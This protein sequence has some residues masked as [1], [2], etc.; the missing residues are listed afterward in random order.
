MSDVRITYNPGYLQELMREPGVQQLVTTAALDVKRGIAS[1]LPGGNRARPFASKAYA[2]AATIV[3][4]H[5]EAEA[6]TEF[7]LGHIF[8]V[9]S[10]TSPA[11]APVRKA[12]VA[13]GLE[14]R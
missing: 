14:I 2:T 1:H 7:R 5:L 4:G 6:G 13:A 9:G 8:E 12:A 11:Y 3:G 10:P